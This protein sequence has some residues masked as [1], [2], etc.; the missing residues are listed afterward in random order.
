MFRSTC[1]I[2]AA[3]A[4]TAVFTSAARA[5]MSPE[6]IPQ[7]V[8]V[9]GEPLRWTFTDGREA[10][11]HFQRLP[12]TSFQ[13]PFEFVDTSCPREVPRAPRCNLYLPFEVTRFAVKWTKNSN[14]EKVGQSLQYGSQMLQT[15]FSATNYYTKIEPADF[16]TLAPLKISCDDYS[17]M[18]GGT[19]APERL[20]LSAWAAEIMFENPETGVN[21]NTTIGS[22]SSVRF[23]RDASGMMSLAS[24][25]NWNALFSGYL[26]FLFTQGDVFHLVEGQDTAVCESAIKP[27]ASAIRAQA[28]AY[29][30]A[31][32]AVYG[33]YVFGR[34]RLWDYAEGTGGF[35]TFVMR[36]SER[37]I[38]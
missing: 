13:V 7:L 12:A 34:N 1:A 17:W 18:G 14:A 2:S 6:P 9:E 38:E 30:A 37:S 27:D 36:S 31:H 3:F 33:P 10:T 23:E 16:S 20:N 25:G 29:L 5:Q 21:E 8:K 24:T 32:P 11:L 35:I 4:V 26:P 15:E 19:D 28:Q 22:V